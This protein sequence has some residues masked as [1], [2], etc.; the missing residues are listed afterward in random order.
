YRV[1]AESLRVVEK[2]KSRPK[3]QRGIPTFPP[4]RRRLRV[5]LPFPQPTLQL[6]TALL[7]QTP[8]PA[9][10]DTMWVGS[11]TPAVP[12]R[13]ALSSGIIMVCLYVV[14]LLCWFTLPD[15]SGQRIV[16]SCVN[17]S[18]GA[19]WCAQTT[20]LSSGGD[21]EGTRSQWPSGGSGGNIQ[22]THQSGYFRP[23][24]GAH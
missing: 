8:H 18:T 15:S 1:K 21:R 14:G 4:P 9:R 11:T 24:T 10:G 3:K 20:V 2:W 7:A 12:L 23:E 13:K 22:S 19:L 5:F 17:D 6:A 16:K